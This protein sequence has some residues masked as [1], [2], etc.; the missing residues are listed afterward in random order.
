MRNEPVYRAGGF[1]ISPSSF[2]KMNFR[3]AWHAAA[4]GVR[5]DW[6]TEEQ[7]T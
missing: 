1:H 7:C 3:E 4:H 2:F 5:Q 6:V